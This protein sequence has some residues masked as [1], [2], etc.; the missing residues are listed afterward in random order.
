MMIA[1]LTRI[2]PPEAL[3]KGA[4][5]NAA[6]LAI[7]AAIGALGA[8]SA[9]AQSLTDALVM[10]YQNNPNILSQRAHL[11]GQDEEVNQAL[12]GWRPTVTVNGQGGRQWLTQIPGRVLGES[13]VTSWTRCGSLTVTENIYKG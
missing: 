2:W 9:M 12:S 5:C 11:R 6:L 8:K 7:L 3:R 13:S 4:L 1:S 10:A